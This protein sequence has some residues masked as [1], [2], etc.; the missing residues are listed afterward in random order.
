MLK[1]LTSSEKELYEEISNEIL[2]HFNVNE[3][4]KEKPEKNDAYDL[5]SKN[6][7]P[8]A[9]KEVFDILEHLD[10]KLYEKIPNKFIE[11]IKTNM[12]KEYIPKINY[13]KS[14][15]NQPLMKETKVV[16]SLIYRNYFLTDVEKNEISGKTDGNLENT[17]NIT[18]VKKKT[19]KHDPDINKIF[20]SRKNKSIEVKENISLSKDKVRW[21]RKLINK[22]L[23]IV[24]TNKKK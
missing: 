8:K 9:Y 17:L 22:I 14:I 7:N 2:K 16:L 21:Y 20:D 11:F 12:D 3:I 4:H 23:N 15:V 19:I 24:K 10:K 6:L 1:E 18:E 5:L 13:N